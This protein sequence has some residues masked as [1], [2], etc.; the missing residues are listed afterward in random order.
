[1]VRYAMFRTHLAPELFFSDFFKTIPP[2]GFLF[3]MLT[4]L[5]QT[6]RSFV[7]RACGR[8]LTAAFPSGVSAAEA[9]RIQ[10]PRNTR[11]MNTYK[12]LFP[13]AISAAEITGVKHG[14][15][16]RTPKFAFSKRFVMNTY[17]TPRLQL[18]QN[19]HLRKKGGGGGVSCGAATNSFRITSLYN[20]QKQL[21]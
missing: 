8:N 11:R 12:N 4:A 19:A 9:F 14:A 16:S 21:P 13:T 10:R 17:K 7:G 2:A 18:A 1:M 3:A 5:R 15:A 20:E 6:C